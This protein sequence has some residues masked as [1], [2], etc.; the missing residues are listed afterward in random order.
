MEGREHAESGKDRR[1]MM[2]TITRIS[3]EPFNGRRLSARRL[4]T[5][6]LNGMITDTGRTPW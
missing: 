3:M 4:K 5:C 6:R 2:K 1:A